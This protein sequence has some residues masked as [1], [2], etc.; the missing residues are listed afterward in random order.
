MITFSVM[1]KGYTD[2]IIASLVAQLAKAFGTQ[3]EG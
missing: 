2:E 3:P 1:D